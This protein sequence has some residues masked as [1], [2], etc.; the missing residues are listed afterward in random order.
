MKK[1]ISPTDGVE[2]TTPDIQ[3]LEQATKAALNG[4]ALKNPDSTRHRLRSRP[5]LDW[6]GWF[7]LCFPRKKSA[8]N[9]SNKPESPLFPWYAL[10]RGR[11]SVKSL[12]QSVEYRWGICKNKKAKEQ[13]TTKEKKVKT[14]EKRREQR[15]RGRDELRGR[16][17][18]EASNSRAQSET[19]GSF[20]LQ[21]RAL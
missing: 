15:E 9:F 12:S 18:K 5:F 4:G 6:L 7:R 13:K 8:N 10:S 19:I 1:V 21:F 16:D 14:M 17:T 2:T 3:R 20:V 11:D